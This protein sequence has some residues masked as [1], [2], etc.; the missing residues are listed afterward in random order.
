MKTKPYGTLHTGRTI[1]VLFVLAIL[2]GVFPH[3]FLLRY[4]DGTIDRQVDEL[5]AWTQ[6]VK[7]VD[8]EEEEADQP[9]LSLDAEGSDEVSL[10]GEITQDEANI[11]L[12]GRIPR[13]GTEDIEQER[14]LPLTY[15]TS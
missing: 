14:L 2:F 8:S 6:D 15:T 1:G 12:A 7:E 4:M 10:S 13:Q 3:F 11:Q 5:A 9:D